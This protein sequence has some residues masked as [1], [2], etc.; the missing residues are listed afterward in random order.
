VILPEEVINL[1]DER[2]LRSYDAIGRMIVDY[3]VDMEL[4]DE[5]QIAKEMYFGN[6]MYNSSKIRTNY[7]SFVQWL[8]FSYKLSD[9]CSLI[10]CI[11][12]SIYGFKKY[13]KDA[14]YNLKNATEVL[15]YSSENLNDMVGNFKLH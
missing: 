9:G 12:D 15:E 7:R 2:L 5:V 4:Y 14:L 6:L 10:D 1:D 11:Y 8:I 3:I 13:E